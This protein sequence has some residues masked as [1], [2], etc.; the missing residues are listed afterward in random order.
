VGGTID[1]RVLNLNPSTPE[2]VVEN[3][4]LCINSAKAIGCNVND[5]TME[6]IITGDVTNTLH[7]NLTQY[8]NQN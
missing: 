2:A 3:I 8:R 4:N 5:V 1:E 7:F 6:D